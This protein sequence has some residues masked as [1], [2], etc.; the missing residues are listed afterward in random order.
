MV[1]KFNS[2]VGSKKPSIPFGD[3]MTILFL[4]DAIL[5]S[6]IAHFLFFNKVRRTV[7]IHIVKINRSALTKYYEV[8]PESLKKLRLSTYSISLL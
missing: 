7:F 4:W 5:L 2:E 8:P 3:R 1:L 6:P